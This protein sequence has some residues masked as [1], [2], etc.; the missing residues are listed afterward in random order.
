MKKLKLNKRS[1]ARI[2]FDGASRDEQA[3]VRAGAT[4][5]DP[6]CFQTDIKASFC[7]GACFTCPCVPKTGG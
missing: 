4:A 5:I 2:N 6:A 1:I 3:K 7:N